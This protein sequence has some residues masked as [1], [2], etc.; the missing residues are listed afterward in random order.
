MHLSDSLALDVR[1]ELADEPD[2]LFGTRLAH[3]ARLKEEVVADICLSRDCVVKHCE[4]ADACASLSAYA[5]ERRRECTAPGS[6]RFLRVEVAVA[7]P[8]TTRIEAFSSALCPLLAHNLPLGAQLPAARCACTAGVS[9]TLTSAA[10]HTF[11][12][13]RR[14]EMTWSLTRW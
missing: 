5:S 4:C 12:C 11:A 2:D 10:G 6:T 13:A 9:G 8:L 3:A 1:V 7:V 14:G